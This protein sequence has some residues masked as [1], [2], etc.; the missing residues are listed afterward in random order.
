MQ[1]LQSCIC[2]GMRSAASW[3]NKRLLL[4]NMLYNMINLSSVS[5]KL[6]QFCKEIKPQN[7]LPK[8]QLTMLNASCQGCPY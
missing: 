5:V 4:Y 1:K 2:A 8:V 7:L 3:H 6:T